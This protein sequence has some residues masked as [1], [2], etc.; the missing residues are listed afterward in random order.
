[1]TQSAL[2][3][4]RAAD[5]RQHDR[6][7]GAVH[8]ARRHHLRR[9][10]PAAQQRRLSADPHHAVGAR[11]SGTAPSAAP[12]S[13]T[14]ASS[15]ATSPPAPAARCAASRR[16]AGPAGPAGTGRSRRHQLRR[17]AMCRQLAERNHTARNQRVHRRIQP[18]RQRMRLLGDARGRA[19]RA[20]AGAAAAG[21]ITVASA[22]GAKRAGEDL[23]RGR[24]GRAGA[25]SSARLVLTA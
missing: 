2:P 24:R 5:L 10:Q 17:Q 19:E 7:A 6:H 22:G 12:R 21:R 4:P 20:D 8:R 9:H 16:P 25:V 1:M 11:R 23:R 3:R 15:C 14:A 13:A 18:R